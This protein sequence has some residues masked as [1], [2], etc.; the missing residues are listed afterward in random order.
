MILVTGATGS[1]GGH[2]VRRLRQDGVPFKALVRDAAKG[3]SLG[4]DTVLGDFDDPA[5]I[6]AA[7]AGVDRLFL[8]TA[9]AEPVEGEQPMV[10]RQK[11]AVDAAVRAGVSSVVKVSVWHAREGGKL[12][13]GAHWP[14]DQH[15]KA[16][17]LGWS[18]LQPSGFM[19][20]FLALGGVFTAG[21]D[22]I[23]APGDS[24]VSYIDCQDIADC[25]ARLLV[26][27]DRGNAAYVLTGPQALSQSEIAEELSVALGRRV[28]YVDLAPADLAASLTVRGVPARFAADV[29]ELWGAVGRGAQAT[30]TT[31]VRELTGH[32]ART[33][34]EFVRRHRDALRAVS[35]R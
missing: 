17:G 12:A 28:R 18:L 14:A 31:A 16:S 10:R 1:V 2:L 29:A 21:G 20:N 25:A 7:L 33:F 27:P 34:A 9:G 23:G 30:T 8:N 32:E 26:R 22:F 13:E 6:E 3:R 5:S 4:C 11:A 19:Q 15:L 35:G 24:R